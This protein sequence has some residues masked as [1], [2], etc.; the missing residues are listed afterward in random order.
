MV[1]SGKL[2]SVHS[3]FEDVWF[4]FAISDSSTNFLQ[5]A[6]GVAVEILLNIVNDIVRTGG[7]G[8]QKSEKAKSESEANLV[9]VDVFRDVDHSDLLCFD[10]TQHRRG[11]NDD[12]TRKRR[13]KGRK[14]GGEKIRKF[15]D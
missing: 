13:R 9:D 1:T 6:G 10:L 3:F 15:R 12:H 4:R 5:P 2:D 14:G 8:R 11:E 7:R